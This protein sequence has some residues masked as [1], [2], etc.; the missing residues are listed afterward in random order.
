V[1]QHL[2]TWPREHV[3]KCL[4]SYHP[5]DPEELRLLQEQKVKDLYD[6]C[7]FSGH[8]LLLEVIPPADI[9]VD[10]T[11]L[12]RAM[13]RFYNLSIYPDWWKLPSQ[14]SQYWPPIDEVIDRHAPHCRGIVIL[15]LDQPVRQ[16]AQGFQDSCRAKWVKGFA[17]GRTIFGEPAKE[18]LSGKLTDGQLIEHIAARYHEMVTL[19]QQRHQ[20]R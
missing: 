5:D 20:R 11:T 17:V 19:W 14:P 12:P 1:G 7:C 9:S 4:V 8:E 18:W 3:V 10:E 15:G 13:T 2:T 6:A 16:L